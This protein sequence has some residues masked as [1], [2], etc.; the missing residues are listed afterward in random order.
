MSA[1]TRDDVDRIVAE[2]RKEGRTPDLYG[3]DLAG[4]NLVWADLARVNL[5]RAN[6]SGA[7]LAS[8][9]L[10]EA[11]LH[12]ASLH[13]A[14]LCGA[15]LREANL[16]GASM[17]WARLCEASLYGADLSGVAIYGADLREVALREVNLSGVN[18]RGANL[19]GVS[20]VLSVA[21]M[22][23]GH[24]LHW[25]TPEGWATRVGCWP[26]TLDELEAMIATDR[27]WPEAEGDECARRRPVLAAFIALCRAHE[28][29][30][31]DVIEALAKRWAA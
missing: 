29:L 6:L 18:F 15:N 16:R 14:N 9:S 2:A 8:A 11:D 27:G 1:L 30:H 28:A 4:V 23:S 31:P 10:C 26:G 5:H 24:G 17:N 7:T 19:R 25:P 20:E 3:A 22:P 13:G 12:G 21:G